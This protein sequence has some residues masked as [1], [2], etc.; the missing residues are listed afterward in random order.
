MPHDAHAAAHALVESIAAVVLIA[1]G[2]VVLGLM[3][4]RRRLGL[5]S[6]VVRSSASPA[7]TWRS[8]AVVPVVGLAALALLL[9]AVRFVGG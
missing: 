1:A 3:A 8:I 4:R 9:V 6:S 2:L 7:Q 5:A